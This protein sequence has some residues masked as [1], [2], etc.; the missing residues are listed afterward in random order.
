[1]Y[2]FLV[3]AP[4]LLVLTLIRRVRLLRA[5]AK[6][7]VLADGHYTGFNP[8]ADDGKRDFEYVYEGKHYTLAAQHVFE[9]D[10][11]APL[12]IGAPIKVWVDPEHPS[13][14]I[15]VIGYDRIE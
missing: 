3:G 9:R 4:A 15:P 14:G 12:A 6:R 13:R 1:M 5:L 7:G 2:M 10:P 11:G 8:A